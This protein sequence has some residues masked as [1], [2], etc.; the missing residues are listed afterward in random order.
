[1]SPSDRRAVLLGLRIGGAVLLLIG[2]WMVLGGSLA[3]RYGF[4]GVL[5]VMGLFAMVALPALLTRRWRN[6]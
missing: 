1:M 2:L 6:R 5:L 3:G 4:G